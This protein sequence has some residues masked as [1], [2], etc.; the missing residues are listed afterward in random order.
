MKESKQ[1][2]MFIPVEIR[3]GL[4]DNELTV[5]IESEGKHFESVVPREYVQIEIEPFAGRR[6]K[7]RL[8][9]RIVE[10]HGG[11]AWV[12]MPQASFTSQPRI[13]VDEEELVGN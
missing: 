9:V 1:A 5:F 3:P 11:K 7:G 6:G 10:F 12:D 2:Y 8:Q 13:L 4:F